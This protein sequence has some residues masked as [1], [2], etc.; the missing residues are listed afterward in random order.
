MGVVFAKPD[1]G[2]RIIAVA[3]NPEGSLVDLDETLN[4]EL[5]VP[6][7]LI[8]DSSTEIDRTSMLDTADPTDPVD[9]DSNGP[10]EPDPVALE[11]A[12]DDSDPDTTDD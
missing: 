4:G 8:S 6:T 1:Q 9:A 5:V 10:F 7:G 2:D 12:E 11:T 3:R